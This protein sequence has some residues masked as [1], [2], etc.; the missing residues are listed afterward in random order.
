MN[1]KIIST[2]ELIYEADIQFTEMIDYGV[3]M[4]AISSGNIPIPPEGARFDQ[5]F[6]GKL[7]GPKLIGKI[8]GRDHLYVRADGLFKLHLHATVIT[9]D[10]VNI[11]FSSKGIS[12]QVEGEKTTQLR[13][14]VS[15][16]TS[17]EDYKW[18]NYL[19]LWAL[20]TL[21]PV[22]GKAIVKAYDTKA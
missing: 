2:G 14:A 16:F 17:S 12:I 9:E 8:S 5:V 1:T 10:G 3:S 21:D 11:S 20:G 6:E 4:Q 7:H 18:L 19:H 13:S 22:A 15:L